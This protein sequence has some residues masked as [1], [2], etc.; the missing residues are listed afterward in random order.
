MN[1]ANILFITDFFSSRFGSGGFIGESL[2]I[3]H[4]GHFSILLS[5]FASIFAAYCY[6]TASNLKDDNPQRKSWIKLAQASFITH[7]LAVVSIFFFLFIMILN[8]HFEYQY[9]WK[10]SSLDLPLEYII[11]CFWEGSEG[12]FLLWQFWHA[13]IG[14]FLILK[15]SKWES[16]V[17]TVISITQAFLGSMLIGLYFFGMKIGINPF[18][19]LRDVMTD[20][21]VFQR[22]DYLQF[23][24]DGNGLNPLLQNYWMVIHPPVLFLGFASTL[25]PFAFAVAALWKKD[26]TDWVPVALPYTLFAC[27]VLAIGILMGGAW[28]YESLS[29]G[30]FWAWD[31]VENASLVP[32]LILLAGLHTMVAFK[33]SKHGLRATFLFFILSYFFIL[34]STFLTRSGILGDT[35]VHSFTDEGLYMQLVVFMLAVSVPP[36]ILLALNYSKI[37]SPKKEEKTFTREFWMFVG[38]LV[39]LMSALLITYTTSIPLWNKLFGTN[40]APPA[41]PEKF[42]NSYQIFFGMLIGIL[43]GAIQYFRY[44]SENTKTFL[45][46]IS[47]PFVLSIIITIPIAISYELLALRFVLFLFSGVF[48]VLANGFYMVRELKGNLSL[49]GGSLSHIGFG[50]M[51]VGILI[52]QHKQQVISWNLEGIEFGEEF[53][54]KENLE[55][56]LLLKDRPTRMGAYMITYK[57]EN[58][59]GVN[60]YYHVEYVK[61]DEE[62]GE[63]IDSFTLKPNAQINPKMGLVANPSTKRYIHEDIF[64]HVTSVPD[65]SES[66]PETESEHTI[67]IG[68]TFFTS[69]HYIV[70]EALVP[71]PDVDSLTFSD[72]RLGVGAKLAIK[73]FDGSDYSAMPIYLIDM[74]DGNR[75]SVY[76]DFVNK[77]GLEFQINKIL[78]DE[79][80]VIITALESEPANDF[81]I[82]K[83]IIFPYINL[84]WLGSIT[85]FAGF[86]LS[87]KGKKSRK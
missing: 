59:K 68:D 17:M 22:L 46:K 70:L 37:P 71:N 84:V 35:S 57:G 26:Y 1:S 25:I 50:L 29:F 12:S 69:K 72:Q 60:H 31:P 5:F 10:H 55:N 33:S 67:A 9:A 48:A 77:I 74:A 7:G 32:W 87:I 13:A 24:A 27:G 53:E 15:L 41:N 83:A 36:L 62:T 63:I 76:N 79:K 30:G 19:L 73:G 44:R 16:S 47:I 42:Y 45:K 14:F 61:S 34:Y 43:S 23:I 4:L 56:V 2:W 39:L 49:S 21:P 80:K 11:S 66:E 78:A 58:I 40:I 18:L 65:R 51:L 3:G 85:M 20:A 38:G 64:T 75:V 81:I 6:F 82:M 54:E 86:M 52:S 8:H 28:A